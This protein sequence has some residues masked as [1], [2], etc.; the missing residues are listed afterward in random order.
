MIR[1]G[2]VSSFPLKQP[3]ACR[4]E[5]SEERA[6]IAKTDPWPRLLIS[7]S[8]FSLSGASVQAWHAVAVLAGLL[9]LPGSLKLAKAAS[10][11]R[12]LHEPRCLLPCLWTLRLPWPH[13]AAASKVQGSLTDAVHLL[14]HAC[15]RRH[16]TSLVGPVIG[17]Q[18][19]PRSCKCLV[20]PVCPAKPHMEEQL[21]CRQQQ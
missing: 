7:G 2:V 12:L 8:S 17:G 21:T 15:G 16:V 1:P 19:L 14:Q 18:R 3:I 13:K 20:C 9:V 10:L 6:L 5:A 11:L 4:V